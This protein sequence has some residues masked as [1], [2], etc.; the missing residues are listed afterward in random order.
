MSHVLSVFDE[1]QNWIHSKDLPS[2]KCSLCHIFSTLIKMFLSRSLSLFTQENEKLKSELFSM[3]E[4]IV[5]NGKK[6]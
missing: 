2:V 6:L 3:K 1:V 5:E 4:Y